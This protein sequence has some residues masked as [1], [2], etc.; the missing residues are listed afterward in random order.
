MNTWGKSKHLFLICSDKT[1]P[2]GVN[3]CSENSQNKTTSHL[4]I[5]H[6]YAAHCDERISM[7]YLCHRKR[8]QLQTWKLLKPMR[9]SSQW[10]IKG[11]KAYQRCSLTLKQCHMA[12]EICYHIRGVFA[13]E[14]NG[15]CASWKHLSFH[16]VKA[17]KSAQSGEGAQA[18]YHDKRLKDETDLSGI[19]WALGT[20]CMAATLS[21]LFPICFGLCLQAKDSR[22]T[23]MIFYKDS[24]IHMPQTPPFISHTYTCTRTHMYRHTHTH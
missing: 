18:L 24:N 3:I 9:V 10:M 6:N 7:I 2:P 19:S 21:G 23:S 13:Q 8:V 1:F 12:P 4:I 20:Q 15:Y 16:A 11:A 14:H 5:C 22:Q 17:A